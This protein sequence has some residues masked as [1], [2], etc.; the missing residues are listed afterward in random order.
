MKRVVFIIVVLL[1]TIQGF[2]DDTYVPGKAAF[3]EYPANSKDT[4]SVSWKTDIDKNSELSQVC[5]IRAVRLIKKD[6]GFYWQVECIPWFSGTNTIP[7]IRVNND[8]IPSKT[9]YT[10]I[11]KKSL[12]VPPRKKNIPYDGLYIRLLI[13]AIMLFVIIAIIGF[14][15]FKRRIII[16]SII[17]YVAIFLEQYRLLKKLTVLEKKNNWKELDYCIRQYCDSITCALVRHELYKDYIDYIH[18]QS[19]TA[20]EIAMYKKIPEPLKVAIVDI[21]KIIENARWQNS[22]ENY[23]ACC[24][25]AKTLPA[26]FAE[27]VLKGMDQS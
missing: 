4:Q 22:N 2:T 14:L 9:I 15:I 19:L 17:L 13:Y 21:L 11:D 10:S 24:N 27:N 8:V 6:T 18:A 3:F 5:Y 23:I 12:Y 1:F 25:R 7:T 20:S 16:A 26:L